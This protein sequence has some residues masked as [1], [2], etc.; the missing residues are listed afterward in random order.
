MIPFLLVFLGLILIL[1]EFYIPGAIMGILGGV[2]ILGGILFFA[3]QTDSAVPIFYLLSGS[4]AVVLLIRF[5]MWR[6]VHSKS[7]YSIYSNHD[8]AGF[9]ASSYDHTVHWENRNLF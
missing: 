2:S 1:F 8:Q 4:A 9:Q 5:A 7:P 3:S 6:I